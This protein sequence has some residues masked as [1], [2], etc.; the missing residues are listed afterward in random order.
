M[1]VLP[2]CTSERLSCQCPYPYK[3]TNWWYL[4]LHR[5]DIMK[6]IQEPLLLLAFFLNFNSQ[7]QRI[8]S[9]HTNVS[10][11]VHYV[12]IWTSMTLYV[13]LTWRWYQRQLCKIIGNPLSIYFCFIV[14]CSCTHVPTVTDYVLNAYCNKPS[15][16]T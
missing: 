11:L 4:M 2:V 14:H 10:F 3:V 16:C 6:S 1:D 5:S 8:F 9:L 7:N 15:L 12:K 13:K